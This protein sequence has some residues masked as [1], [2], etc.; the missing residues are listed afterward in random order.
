MNYQGLAKRLE[1]FQTVFSVARALNIN[2]RTAIN[3][4]YKLRRNGYLQT[5]RGHKKIRLYYIKP[6]VK[7]KIDYLSMYDIINK[8]SKVKITPRYNYI[9]HYKLSIEEALVKALKSQDFRT[10]L[11]S[12]GLFNY[13]NWSRLY[14]LAKKEKIARNIGAL[15]DVIRKIIRIKKMDKRTRNVLLKAEGKKFLINKFKFK[16]KDFR[17][18]GKLW[19]VFIPFNK[20]DLRVYKE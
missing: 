18:I 16:S 9:S 14:K 5:S 13:I 10:I 3:Y 4:L 8:Y 15:Y 12:L 1:G 2:N 11:A 6:F 20:Q 7:Q 17:D 19:K